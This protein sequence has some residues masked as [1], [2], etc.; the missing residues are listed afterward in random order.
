MAAELLLT[1]IITIS[2]VSDCDRRNKCY[3]AIHAL[4]EHT[5]KN[6]ERQNRSVAKKIFLNVI[7]F[8]FLFLLYVF[9][10]ASNVKSK[11]LAAVSLWL[12]TC[13]S[14]PAVG[15]CVLLLRTVILGII[16]VEEWHDAV[17]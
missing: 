1:K 8:V 14:G 3:A 17:V 12:T 16:G 5:E 7:K 4:T 10:L 9:C 2:A 15:L 6:W 13:L 11:Y